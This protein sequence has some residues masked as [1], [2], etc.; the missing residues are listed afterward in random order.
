MR[1]YAFWR[2]TSSWRV[3]LTLGLK[4]VPFEYV[5]IDFGGGEQHRAAH[6]ARSPMGQIPVLEW[7]EGGRTVR[8]TQS[9]AIIE[10]LEERYP[11]GARLL[12]KDL[13]A[14]ARARQLAE[15]VNSGIQPLGPPLVSGFVKEK[16]GGD[17]K[18]WTVHW[19]ER[20]LVALEALAQ[21]S[22]GRYLVGDEIT[23]ADLCLV[24][25]LFGA[26]AN[27]IDLAR[28]PTLLRAEAE[29]MKHP[30]FQRCVPD[31]QPDSPGMIAAA[32]VEMP[33]C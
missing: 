16:F 8:L 20:G 9:L 29:C 19:T 33:Q 18:A 24:P 2:S 15:V 4:D 21:D 11:A 26:R 7:E 32:K 17:P 23:I 31:Q 25:Q 10:Y 1:L 13:L 6:L 5:A 14:R 3:R 12:P 30:V 22:A 28:F 27:G